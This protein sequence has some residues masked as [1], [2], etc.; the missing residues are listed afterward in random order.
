MTNVFDIEPAFKVDTANSYL[1]AYRHMRSFF[2]DKE[3]FSE[4]DFVC[5]AH[6][7]YGWMPTILELHTQQVTLAEAAALLTLAKRERHLSDADIQRVAG[8]VNN[9]LVG[10]SKLLH[11]V[12]PERFAIWDSR[13][14]AFVHQTT[15]H[16]Y[17]MKSVSAYREYLSLLST[18]SADARMPAFH[19][20]VN[21]KLGYSVSAFRALE[22]VM[23]QHRND[24]ALEAEL[25]VAGKLAA[26]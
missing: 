6:M 10:A 18:L 25:P 4:S 16:F 3:V 14:Y 19:A 15:A 17:R 13:I 7:V 2:E 21:K 20:S 26:P 24:P 23:F 1:A 8:V 5:G 11:F 9:S 22:L 12:D